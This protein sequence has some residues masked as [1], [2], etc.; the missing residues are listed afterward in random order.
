MGVGQKAEKRTFS[1]IMFLLLIVWTFLKNVFMYYLYNYR[2]TLNETIKAKKKFLLKSP[3]ITEVQKDSYKSLKQKQQ[4]T[5][6]T[7]FS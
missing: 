5:L 2:K 7:I 4:E 6:S 3:W 1:I